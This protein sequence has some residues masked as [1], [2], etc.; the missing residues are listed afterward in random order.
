MSIPRSYF[1]QVVDSPISVTLYGFCDASVCAYAAVIYLVTRTDDDTHVQ[2]VV[3]KTRVAPLQAQTIP[4][5]ELLSAYLLSKLMVSVLGSLLVTLP[6]LKAQ[7]YT[8]SQI[9]LYWICGTNKEWKPFVQ[10]RVN[11]IR[12]NVSPSLWNYCPGV[13][14]PADLPS[15][16]LSALETAM[17]QLW[18][19][20]PNWLYE[21]FPWK[22]PENTSM[23][24][25]C[26][27]ELKATASHLS[28]L[29]TD[30]KGSVDKLLSCNKFSSLSKLLRVTA[31]IVKAIKRFKGAAAD[32]CTS[33]TPEELIQAEILWIKDAQQPL[34]SQK[35]FQDSTEAVKSVPGRENDLAL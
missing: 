18:R 26:A 7:C 13:S 11:E 4:R 28:L 25:E 34:E 15:R 9:A 16:G 29:T 14:N 3:S 24:E 8:D 21:N 23:P 19:Q 5:L 1:H 22:S 20:G 31:L 33:L 2:F 32:D 27:I 35:D 17:S 12:R 30:A 10:N 6:Q